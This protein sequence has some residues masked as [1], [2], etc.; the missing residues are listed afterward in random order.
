MEC[1]G[2]SERKRGKQMNKE[3]KMAKREARGNAR[4]GQPPTH[5][6]NQKAFPAHVNVCACARA[7]MR[8]SMLPYTSKSWIIQSCKPQSSLSGDA[9]FGALLLLLFLLLIFVHK[10]GCQGFFR[11]HLTLYRSPSPLPLPAKQQNNH[12]LCQLSS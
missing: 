3:E 10:K 6:Q 4:P 1:E 2:R 11:M 7:S 8:V 5:S 9:T 12:Q